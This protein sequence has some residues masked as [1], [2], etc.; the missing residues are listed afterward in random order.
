MAK[1]DRWSPAQSVSMN[2]MGKELRFAFVWFWWV[3]FIT[4]SSP[5]MESDHERR[6]VRTANAIGKTRPIDIHKVD[7]F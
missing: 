3:F 4:H 7:H 5:A 1:S 2:I 6:V